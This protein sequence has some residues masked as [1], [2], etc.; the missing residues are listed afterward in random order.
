MLEQLTERVQSWVDRLR[1]GGVLSA[2]EIGASL[3]QLRTTLLDADVHQ[4]VVAS[5]LDRVQARAAQLR[6][7]ESVNTGDRVVAL[8]AQELASLLGDRHRPL[9]LS[10]EPPTV[11]M[12]V[13]LQGAGKTTTAGKLAR[14]LKQ[15]GRRLLLVAADP[16][17]PA[18]TE[19]LQALGRQM[20]VD[21]LGAPSRPASVEGGDAGRETAVALCREAVD[22]AR[23]RATE[24]V[25]IDT[26][27]RLHIDQ[28]LMDE[29]RAIHEAVT[30]QEVWLVVDGMMGQEAVT[31]TRAFAAAVPVSGLV[32]TKLDGDARGG[33]LLSIRAVTGLAVSYLGTGEKME[34]LEPFHPDRMVSRLLGR[35]DL[36]SLLERVA[37]AQPGP[38]RAAE[39]ARKIRR[40]ELTLEDFRAQLAQMSS[41]GP[42]EDLL[43]MVPGGHRLKGAV[44]EGAAQAQITRATAIIDSMTRQER[45][46]P[47][48]LNGRRRI[49]IAKGSGT[50]VQDVNQLVRQFYE[51]RRMM[52]H[53]AGQS[54]RRGRAG[55]RRL[56][57]S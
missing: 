18:A 30:P 9:K 44:T 7:Q 12:L 32:M 14:L 2:E 55:L 5:L 36:Q 48:V 15:Q 11:I 50:T 10:S 27:G 25:I 43:A 51:A 8:V 41:M 54:D 31:T 57:G 24:V 56:L 20:L 37:T 16:R 21:V 52:K 40:E 47:D 46:A 45:R 28:A 1:R 35:G 13:G 17:R 33:A 22:R 26:A 42:V 38:D 53:A 19:Q 4:E 6:V 34:A 23:S 3:G 29:L 39:L 49:R